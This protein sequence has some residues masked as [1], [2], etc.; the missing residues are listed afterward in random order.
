LDVEFSWSPSGA[1][2]D[3]FQYSLRTRF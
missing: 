1:L 3:V 2:G